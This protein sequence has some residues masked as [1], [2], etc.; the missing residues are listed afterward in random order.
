MTDHKKNSIMMKFYIAGRVSGI[1]RVD[2]LINFKR[3]ERTLL[4]NGMDFVNPLRLVKEN[5]TP[6]EAM[7]IL[8]PAM[9][10]C[11]G[12]LLLNDWKFSE[13]ARIEEMLA[14][15][16]GLRIIEEDDLY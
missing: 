8:I 9:L 5:T 14:R 13:G 15:Y 3:G 11:D 7:R 12:I 4:A 2:A 16:A 6:L 1:T 10:D